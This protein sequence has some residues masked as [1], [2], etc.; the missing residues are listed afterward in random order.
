MTRPEQ[1][2]TNRR[3]GQEKRE[4]SF[5]P[6]GISAPGQAEPWKKHRFACCLTHDID[7]V[8]KYD[9]FFHWIR[10]TGADLLRRGNPVM[11]VRRLAEGPC[12]SGGVFR[13]DFKW[14]IETEKKLGVTASYFFLV[15]DRT[16]MGGYPF[17]ETIDMVKAVEEA[18]ME[19]GLHASFDSYDKEVLLSM[20]KLQ[21]DSIVKNKRYGVRQHYL[22]FAV[23]GTWKIQ[24]KLGFLYDCTFGWRDHEG[25][26]AGTCRPFR[27]VDPQTGKE[28]GIWEIPLTVMDGTLAHYRKLSPGEGLAVMKSLVLEVKKARGV[29]CL[30]WHNSSL[31]STDWRG[32]RDTYIRILDFISDQDGWIAAGREIIDAWAGPAAGGGLK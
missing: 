18:G 31:D 14:L 7:H 25:F 27:P 9:S 20:E 11:M 15:H 23:P 28:F 17:A 32:W 30:L 12:R 1:G 2:I 21:M 6:P 8:Q 24:G 13:K 22:N 3:H 5:V 4:A 19:A 16:P 29:F 10:R 26:R